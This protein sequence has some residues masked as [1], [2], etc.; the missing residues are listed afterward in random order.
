MGRL[1]EIYDEMFTL[2][3]LIRYG[4][5]D[6][7]MKNTRNHKENYGKSN[8]VLYDI[9]NMETFSDFLQENEDFVTTYT[10]LKSSEYVWTEPVYF[11]VRKNNF[12]RREYKMPNIYSYLQLA[13]YIVL[14]KKE[15]IE[16]FMDNETSTSKFFNKIS[17]S[18]TVEIKDRL[19]R[20]GNKQLHLDLTNFFPTIYTHSI[21]WMLDGKA[22][23]KTSR[24]G[25]AND[26]DKLIERCQY[27]E[28][29]GLPTGNLLTRIIAELYMCKFDKRVKNYLCN[30]VKYYRYVDDVVYPHNS[31]KEATKLLTA[32]QTIC[33]EMGLFLNENKIHIEEFPFSYLLNKQDVFHYFD[34]I[35][36]YGNS[37]SRRLYNFSREI[38]NYIDYCIQAESNGNKGSIKGCFSVV[39]NMLTNR[40]KDS[41]FSKQDIA[42]IFMET[43]SVTNFNLYQRFIELSFRDASLANRFINFTKKLVKL[44][45]PKEKIKERVR[46]FFDEN[47]ESLCIE[48]ENYREKNYHQ[49]LYQIFLY[50]VYFN[51][52]G[53]FSCEKLLDF[54]ETNDEY[55]I[56][57]NDYVLCLVIISYF[58]N[59]YNKSSNGNDKLANTLDNFFE[60]VNGIYGRGIDSKKGGSIMA[61]GYWFLRYFVFRLVREKKLITNKENQ[62]N[63]NANKAIE[64]GSNRGI[65]KFFIKLLDEKVDFVSFG[66]DGNFQYF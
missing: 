29:H 18:T 38:S 65:D 53:H 43:D 54:F 20:H 62:N 19:L 46:S 50:L 2:D 60:K 44:G 31:N 25:F 55:L 22:T 45:V 52:T 35:T 1:E 8:S 5:Y 27:G 32:Y 23:A 64:V 51:V 34:K 7:E 12:A 9:F 37:K 33:R 4:Y 49:E 40:L 16:A 24:V 57:N 26:L 3:Y 66:I 41:V 59:G 10:T 11:S 6:I 17:F 47:K 48:V 30:D 63:L 56:E 58:L 42:N 36:L 39:T 28:T 61:M 15:F 13:N 14:N 21:V